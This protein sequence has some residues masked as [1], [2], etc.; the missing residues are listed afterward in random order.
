MDFWEHVAIVGVIVSLTISLAVTAIFVGKQVLVRR[1]SQRAAFIRAYAFPP[2]LLDKLAHLHPSLTHEERQLVSIGLRQFFIAYLRSGKKFISMP[3][4]VA[5]DLWHEFIL[6]TRDY[7][8]FC[9]K[10]FASFLHHTPSVALS[11]NR[12]TNEGLRRVWWHTCREEKI[13]P[14]NPRRLPLIFA[15]DEKLKI[16]GGFRYHPRC[17]E[18]RK[19]GDGTVYCGGD[20]SSV[21]F[22]GGTEGFGEGNPSSAP[23]TDST[24]GESWEGDWDTD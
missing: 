19:N 10:A 16:R 20:F 9:G 6:Y 8:Q 12:K 1:Q 11:E 18:L 4:R 23:A 17:A 22:D 3:S 7:Q 2:G 5:D 24:G 13:D 14:Y 21:D 15:L